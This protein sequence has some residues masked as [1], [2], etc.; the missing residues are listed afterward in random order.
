M[1]GDIFPSFVSPFV[2]HSKRYPILLFEI[3][4]LESSVSLKTN[5]MSVHSVYAH[6]NQRGCRVI[7]H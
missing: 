1:N 6:F 3:K 7:N 4:L 2:V 5:F